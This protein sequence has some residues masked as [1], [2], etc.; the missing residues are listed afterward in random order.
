MLS[1]LLSLKVS[2]YMKISSRKARSSIAM[3]D[4]VDILL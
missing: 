2:D 4:T 3:T 1:S